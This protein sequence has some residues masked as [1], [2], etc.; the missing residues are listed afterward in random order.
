[1]CS[2]LAEKELNT[3]MY[4]NLR[5]TESSVGINKG[6]EIILFIYLISWSMGSCNRDKD[7]IIVLWE[8]L[9][10]DYIRIIIFFDGKQNISTAFQNGV[11]EGLDFSRFDK[12]RDDD[13]IGRPLEAD[14]AEQT[15]HQTVKEVTSSSELHKQGQPSEAEVI[16][17]EFE[18]LSSHWLFHS[19]TGGEL[20]QQKS[21][22]RKTSSIF[23]CLTT[24]PFASMVFDYCLMLWRFNADPRLIIALNF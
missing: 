4:S 7:S 16:F 20:F 8:L 3:K 19:F 23:V 6:S 10:C 13:V 21:I 14:E 11:V 24:Y 1:M 2:F 17:E 12:I 18:L 5:E 9:F 15:A 22:L